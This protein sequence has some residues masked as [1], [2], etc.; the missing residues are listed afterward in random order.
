M[1][2]FLYSVSDH[3]QNGPRSDAAAGLKKH[4]KKTLR[5]KLYPK[6]YSHGDKRS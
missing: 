6:R 4:T 1:V 3:Y 5:E 2:N